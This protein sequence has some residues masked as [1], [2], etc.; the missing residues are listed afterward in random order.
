MKKILSIVFA[1]LLVVSITGVAI[2]HQA[3]YQAKVT[4]EGGSTIT[5]PVYAAAA[6]DAGD[7]LVWA[8]AD[9]TGDNDMWVATTTTAD[10]GTVAGI[11]ILDLDLLDLRLTEVQDSVNLLLFLCERED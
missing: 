8:I 2:S 9:S 3:T 5:V 4:N 10:T 1:I 7:V 6:L 11:T